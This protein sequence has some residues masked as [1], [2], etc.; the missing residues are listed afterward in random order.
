L[1]RQ[2]LDR[3]NK[4]GGSYEK[5]IGSVILGFYI[6]SIGRY[7]DILDLWPDFD[8]P[9]FADRLERKSPQYRAADRLLYGICTTLGRPVWDGQIVRIHVAAPPKLDRRQQLR[10]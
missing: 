6:R 8:D 5:D 2:L 10:Q 9:L 1:S 4:P 3:A 7:T